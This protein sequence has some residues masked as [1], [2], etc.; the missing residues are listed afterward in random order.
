M[1]KQFKRRLHG[2]AKKHRDRLIVADYLAGMHPVDLS[3]KYDLSGPHINRVLSASGHARP[4]GPAS[5]RQQYQDEL[6]KR[7]QTMNSD[8]FGDLSS[9]SID[10][11]ADF[12]RGIS[13][14][15]IAG[16]HGITRQA[17]HAAIKRAQKARDEA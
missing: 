17:V 7:L 1:D 3:K 16:E 14:I 11:L 8:R 5:W 2:E 10:M 9:R 13:M 12:E 6:A 4:R 15:Q